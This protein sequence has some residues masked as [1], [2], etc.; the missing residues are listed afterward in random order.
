M[1]YLL[2]ITNALKNFD[3]K[4]FKY[5][6]ANPVNVLDFKT[7]TIEQFNAELVRD[8]L[9][10]IDKAVKI[11]NEKGTNLLHAHK[12]FKLGIFL[13]GM[14]VMFVCSILFFTKKEN[15]SITIQHPIEIKNL[16][17]MLK[18]NRPLIIIQKD[19]KKN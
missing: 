2:S 17:S 5:P 10:S 6:R 12:A 19:T 3:I 4:K 16:D 8:Y 14:L 15:S 1:F 18:K 7:N 9:Y 11:N 13:T